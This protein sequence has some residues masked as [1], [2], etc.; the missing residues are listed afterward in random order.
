MDRVDVFKEMVNIF[1]P[2]KTVSLNHMMTET[3][4]LSSMKQDVRVAMRDAYPFYCNP[5][6]G[7]SSH[8]AQ[9]NYMENELDNAWQVL[10][11]GASLWYMCQAGSDWLTTP[12]GPDQYLMRPTPMTIRSQVWT[13]L[14]HGTTGYI[15]WLYGGG[16]YD[17]PTKPPTGSY[18]VPQGIL[19]EKWNPTEAF[20]EASKLARKLIPVGPTLASLQRTQIELAT[21]HRDVRAYLFSGKGNHAWVVIYNRSFKQSIG[22]KIRLPFRLARSVKDLLTN[23]KIPVQN[24]DKQSTVFGVTIDPAG[25]AVVDLGVQVPKLSS[26]PVWGQNVYI[27]GVPH[28]DLKISRS[29]AGMW[30]FH[31]SRDFQQQVNDWV[32]DITDTDM[33]L[34]NWNDPTKNDMNG[35]TGSRV[36]YKMGFPS[37]FNN[38]AARIIV[39]NHTDSI[40]RTASLEYSIDGINYI[41]LATQKFGAGAAIEV[42]GQVNLKEPV[43]RLWLRIGLSNT[44]PYIVLKSLSCDI[45]MIAMLREQ[46]SA[47]SYILQST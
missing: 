13:G 47:L 17:D 30:N 2:A 27:N 31:Y 46:R 41:P 22:A 11:A 20:L 35:L 6:C 33:N 25:G 5:L 40:E 14:A 43:Y 18:A 45:S 8:E 34:Q 3:I 26:T 37:L 23:T 42:K 24:P 28:P 36:V 44:N 15:F 19:D 10:P 12:N 16:I 29:N 32:T 9:M 7:P 21:D 38:I 1:A 39:A 4:R